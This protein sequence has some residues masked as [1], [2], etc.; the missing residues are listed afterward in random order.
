M[1]K[2]AEE[3]NKLLTVLKHGYGFWEINNYVRC[4]IV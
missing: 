4:G 3:V 1:R 2:S